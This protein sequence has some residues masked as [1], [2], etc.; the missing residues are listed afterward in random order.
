[1][2]R[3]QHATSCGAACCCQLL[4]DL[5]L[6]VTEADV[7][8]RAGFVPGRPL[9]ANALVKALN[10]LHPGASYKGGSVD[11]SVL[12]ALVARG[13]FLALLKVT[14]G[15]HW[16]IV[17]RL[18]PLVSEGHVEIRDPAG[19]HEDA[20]VGAEAIMALDEFHQRWLNTT[21]CVVFRET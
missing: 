14:H 20:H 16:V 5:G 12:D 19:S 11:P 1:M 15:K 4:L 8:L 17:D 2:V 7:C 21:N 18:A 9:S 13:P 6:Q 10:A 3:Q